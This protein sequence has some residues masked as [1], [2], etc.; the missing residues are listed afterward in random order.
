MEN[1]FMWNEIIDDNDLKKFL[2][3]TGYFH[4]S[5]IKELKYLSGAYVNDELSMYPINDCRVLN[6]IIQR[7]SEF[8]STIELEFEG[9]KYLKLF[10][11]NEQY[12]CEILASTMII[13]NDSI[14]WCDC[15]SV[16]EGDIDSYDGTLICASKLRWRSIDNMLGKKNFFDSIL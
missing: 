1:E 9:L 13:K 8:L 2:Q 12:T 16:S 3:E 4:D 14:Y 5:C 15:G 6:V 7:Q 11:I 10:P